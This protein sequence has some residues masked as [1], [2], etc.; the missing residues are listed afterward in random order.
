MEKVLGEKKSAGDK[1]F[2][3]YFP[4]GDFKMGD[5]ISRVGE[6]I[7]DGID[8]L[9]LGIPYERPVLDGAV[10]ASSMAR[11]LEVTSPAAAV[12]SISALRN[13]YPDVCLQIMTYYEV[14]EAMGVDVFCERVAAV[15]VDGVLAPNVPDAAKA[16]LS[17]ALERNGL[18]EPL[19]V[20]IDLADEDVAGYAAAG[21]G[22]LFLQ[23]QEGKTGP[24]EGVSPR[25]ADDIA[26]LRNAGATAALCAG[27]GI[28][29][30]SQVKSLMAM[31][32]DGVIVGSSIIEAVLEGNSREY[33]SSLRAALDE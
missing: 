2:V 10:V 30:P 15:G 31:G 13:A 21:R 27:F 22:Y 23:A 26:R 24:R 9:E 12:D 32:A 16:A 19:F 6:F 8:V 20:P 29:R 4:L 7:D 1:I 3:G 17:E 28:S 14:I 33:I 11:A 25:V 18:I 5:A